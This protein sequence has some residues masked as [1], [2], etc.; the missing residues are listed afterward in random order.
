[1]RSSAHVDLENNTS[2]SYANRLF[3]VTPAEFS[4]MPEE[5]SQFLNENAPKLIF[6]M[7]M[8]EKDIYKNNE[9]LKISPLPPTAGSTLERVWG[10]FLQ[11]HALIVAEESFDLPTAL[12]LSP[13]NLHFLLYKVSPA[14]PIFG[15][16]KSNA[17]EIEKFLTNNTLSLQQ[18]TQTNSET[19]LLCRDFSLAT[20]HLL[21]LDGVSWETLTKL[22]TSALKPIL[23]NYRGIKN[24]VTF[25]PK[26]ED[27]VIEP[28][29]SFSQVVGLF[30]KKPDIAA[31]MFDTN[32]SLVLRRLVREN[33]ESFTFD[34]ISQSTKEE[35]EQ[36]FDE[37]QAITSPSRQDKS[38]SVRFLGAKKALEEKR[39]GPANDQYEQDT[40]ELL[41][42]SE[43]RLAIKYLRE[44]YQLSFEQLYCLSVSNLK[45]VLDKTKAILT[46]LDEQFVPR[47]REFMEL[48]RL[49]TQNIIKSPHTDL[50]SEIEDQGKA[51]L[52]P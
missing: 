52:S 3:G 14:Q 16:L 13:N 2:F 42:S 45:P 8:A 37:D 7:E 35:V 33:L 11:L 41:T 18:Y 24:L 28:F 46:K 29:V 36:I 32:N 19:R 4:S 40:V 49:V 50:G 21:A 44:A 23:E 20:Q 12:T 51:S 5:D 6:F 48:E 17:T 27:K 10:S 1:M 9:S 39:D 22:D 38:S 31:L 43:N 47:P 15:E 26:R 30:E 25:C 34:K